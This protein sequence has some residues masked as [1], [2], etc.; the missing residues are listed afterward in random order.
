MGAT[1]TSLSILTEGL[2]I[3]GTGFVGATWYTDDVPANVVHFVGAVSAAHPG[4]GRSAAQRAL[5]VHLWHELK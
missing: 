3:P 4:I 5:R 2:E 1:S